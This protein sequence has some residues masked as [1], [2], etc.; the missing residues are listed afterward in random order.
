MNNIE[1]E[2]R[3]AIILSKVAAST[4]NLCSATDEAIAK[5]ALK[6]LRKLYADMN[7]V[8]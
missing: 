4:T 2:Q 3:E 7:K 6:N 8:K 5:Q 1:R